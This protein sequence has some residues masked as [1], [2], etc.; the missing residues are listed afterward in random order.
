MAHQLQQ[1]SR[2][3]CQPNAG[4]QLS[5]LQLVNANDVTQLLLW[6]W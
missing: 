3:A 6:N 2:M 5:R 4:I 1:P